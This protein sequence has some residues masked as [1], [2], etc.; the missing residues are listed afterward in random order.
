MIRKL[1][2]KL[3]MASLLS[4]LLV[5]GEILCAAAALN[6]RQITADADAVLA[7]LRENDGSFPTGGP[8]GEILPPPRAAVRKGSAGFPR[9]SRTNR[10]TFPCFSPKAAESFP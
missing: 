9:N 6:Y 1:R 8:P 7:I 10:A 3:V 4:L 2:I 5:L